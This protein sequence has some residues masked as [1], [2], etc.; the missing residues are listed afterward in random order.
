M[1]FPSP[2]T[3][4]V[5]ALRVRATV[6]AALIATVGLVACRQPTAPGERQ[7]VRANASG[8]QQVGARGAAGLRRPATDGSAPQDSVPADSTGTDG[9]GREFWW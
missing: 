8:Q 7:I 5:R 6:C 4:S 9:G 1:S 2:V 3:R